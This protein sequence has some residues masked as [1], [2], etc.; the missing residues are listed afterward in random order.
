MVITR[1]GALFLTDSRYTTQA[2]DEVKGPFSIE[3]AADLYKAAATHVKR[4]RIGTLLFEGRAVNYSAYL[5]LRRL[6]RGCRLRSVTSLLEKIRAVKDPFEVRKIKR[7]IGV[8]NR[9]FRAA[10][11]EIRPGRRERDVSLDLEFLMKRAGAEGLA[12]D[13]IVASGPRSALPHGKASERRIKKGEFVIVDMGVIVGGYNSDKTRTFITGRPTKRQ[14]E[15][16]NT[17]R[18]AHDIAIEKVRP[19][20]EAKEVDRAARDYIE[21][22]GFGK[23]FGHGTGHGVGLDIHEGPVI[24]PRSSEILKEGMVFTIEPGIYIPGWGGV[25]IEDMVVVTGKGCRVLTED[26]YDRAFFHPED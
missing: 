9:G 20:I 25:R 1:T 11:D 22:A 3:E 5:R 15:V 7:S 8:L 21:R 13:T 23:Y 14:R 16:Y 12:F 18:D 19:G 17:V 6:L 10:L 2:S 26:G 4:R 24:G